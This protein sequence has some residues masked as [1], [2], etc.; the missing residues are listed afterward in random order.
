MAKKAEEEAAAEKL[1]LEKEKVEAEAK[2]KA[3][4]EATKVASKQVM[5]ESSPVGGGDTGVV[6]DMPSGGRVQRE[7][8]LKSDVERYRDRAYK[9]E[10][11]VKALERDHALAQN[12]WTEAC[13]VTNQKMM[14]LEEHIQA[15][16]NENSKL[17]E[18]SEV[19]EKEAWVKEKAALTEE[20]ASL[21]ESL[22]LSQTEAEN[23]KSLLDEA[24]VAQEKAQ[25]SIRWVMT[26]GIAGIFKRFWN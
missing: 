16:R 11:K 24:N 3:D 23:A 15:L 1:R 14:R 2:A 13:Q 5:S 10:D 25:E 4:E 6:G 18:T 7:E 22:T 12:R 8:K 26:E 17:Q 19:S 21:E 20:R 9:S